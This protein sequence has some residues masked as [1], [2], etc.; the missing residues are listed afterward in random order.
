MYMREMGTV[1]LLTREGEI[2][3]AKRIEG[4]LMAM[5]EAISASPATIA[6]ILR[7]SDEIRE[8]KVVIST[9]VDGFS[10]ANEADDFV[11]EEDFDEYDEAD[12]DDGKGGSKALTKKL[13]ELKREALSRF[14]RIR[15]LFEK[16]HKIYDKEGYGT[17]AYMKTQHALSEELMTIRFT[18]KTIEKLCDMVRGQVDDVRKKERELRRIIVDKCGYAA[19]KIADFMALTG[20]PAQPAEPEVGRKAGRRRQALERQS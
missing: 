6:E 18:A 12:D 8:G 17:P 4:G 20:L 16:V 15:E 19:R 9:V 1:E 11:A 13:E 5:M 2:E 7:M 3:I 14:D 10:N